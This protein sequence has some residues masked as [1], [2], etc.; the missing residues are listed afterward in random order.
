MRRVLSR[1]SAAQKA[2]FFGLSCAGVLLT[3][4]APARSQAPNFPVFTVQSYMGRCLTFGQAAGSP[5]FIDDCANGVAQQISVEEFSPSVSK[6]LLPGTAGVPTPPTAHQVRLHAGAQCL[7]AG[8]GQLVEGVAVALA[9]CSFAAGQIF[10]LDG[11]SIILDSD[12]DLVVQLGKSDTRPKAPLALAHRNLSDT[13][14]WDFIAVDGSRRPPTSVFVSVTQ[15]AGLQQALAEAGPNSVIQI[16]GDIAFPALAKALAV[17][18]GVTIRGDR[19]GVP[20]GPQLSLS[21]DSGVVPASSLGFTGFIEALGGN[22]RITGL[23]VRGPSRA[24]CDEDPDASC[25]QHAVAGVITEVANDDVKLIIDHN[26]VSDWTRAAVDLYTWLGEPSPPTCSQPPLYR[27]RNVV[28]ARNFIHDNRQRGNNAPGGSDADGYGI[29]AGWGSHPLIAENMFLDNVHSVTSDGTPFAGYTVRD[30]LFLSPGSF[31]HASANIDMHGSGTDHDG[32]IGGSGVDVVRNTFLDG[33]DQ[34]FSMRGYPCD[35][36]ADNFQGNVVQQSIESAINWEVGGPPPAYLKIDSR[37][38]TPPSP[39]PPP[40]PGPPPFSLLD[41][42]QRLGVGDFDGD[43]K[44][45]LFLATGAGWF[46]A[47][48]A[49]AEWRFLSSKTETVNNLLFGDFDGDGRTD[50]FMQVGANWMVSW[51][52]RSPWQLLSNRSADWSPPGTGG[53]SHGMLDLAVGDFVGDK[54]ADVFYADGVNWYVSDGGVGPLIPFAVSSFRIPDLAFGHFDKDHIRDPK[55]DIAGVVDNQWMA[56]FAHGEHI[57]KPLR[58]AL[59]ATMAGLVVADFDGDGLD[60]IATVGPGAWRVS[61]DGVNDWTPLNTAA[62]FLV[63]GRFDQQ[64]SQGSDIL[65]WNGNGIFM[66]P[67]GTGASQQQSRQNMR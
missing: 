63:A 7:A 28:I 27:N 55:T 22:V 12:R 23:R 54:R 65:T 6:P 15:A 61:K 45:D 64:R 18:S 50:V 32:G 16:A 33:A 40:P 5:V 11:D 37:F 67:A 8:P 2:L 4:A 42:T 51:G 59:T 53:G 35:G 48:G 52:G 56:V 13:E 41:P 26:D 58:S 43:G 29:A 36:E 9:P 38:V 31:S 30:S 21:V 14:F 24:D 49:N 25:S 47:P 62:N 10:V 34:V 20:L 46:Y 57:W 60:D 66:L 3:L 39:R 1:L 44:D 19:R 17:K